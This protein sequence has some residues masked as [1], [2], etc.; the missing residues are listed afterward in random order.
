MEIADNLPVYLQS[1]PKK[2]KQLPAGYRPR[3]AGNV[4]QDL[5]SDLPAYLEKEQRKP[6]R[7]QEELFRK[8]L[9]PAATATTAAA[10]AGAVGSSSPDRRR[11]ASA[12]P[13]RPASDEEPAYFQVRVHKD[14]KLRAAAAVDDGSAGLLLPSMQS[15]GKDIVNRRC[16]DQ[17]MDMRRPQTAKERRPEVIAAPSPPAPAPIPVAVEEPAPERWLL[18]DKHRYYGHG[19]V[20]TDITPKAVPENHF[21]DPQDEGRKRESKSYKVVRDHQTKGFNIISNI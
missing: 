2:D 12:H 7:V 16:N 21:N 1:S 18:P 9:I 20:N 11:P 15:K 14:S 8:P 5:P 4:R 3:T 19:R 13:R 10:P 17:R 6:A